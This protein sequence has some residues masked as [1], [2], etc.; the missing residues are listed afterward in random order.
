MVQQ[1]RC[2]SNPWSNEKFVQFY[3]QRKLVM[4]KRDCTLPT[5]AIFCPH[6][7]TN[8]K[9]YPFCGEDTDFCGEDTDFCEKT[10]EI[11]T[12]ETS[13][14]FTRKAVVNETSLR[15]LSHIC[16][17]TIGI[18]ASQLYPFSMCHDMS[19]GLG[20]ATS[21][22]SF[23]KAYK[24]SETKKSLSLTSGLTVRTSSRSKIYLHV[25]PLSVNGDTTMPM[26]KTL[27]IIRT[28]D[29]V[30]L[31]NNK[32]WRYFK[33]G[34]YQHLDGIKTNNYRRLGINIEWL[35][36]KISSSG[37]TTKM[38]F[39]PLKQWKICSILSP[40]KLV[41]L[42]R[43]CTLPTLAIFCPHKWTNEKFYPFCGEDT[44]FCE[45]TREILTVE[46]SIVF[47]RKAVV[48]ETSLRN[49]SHICK[50]TIG[51]DASQLYPFS[52]CHDMSLGL[53]G[54]TSLDSFLKAYKASDTKR[55]FPY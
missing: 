22:D 5:L 14:V 9:F 6:K 53:G 38:L 21:L 15:N 12:G 11:L 24:S 44:D 37:T 39:Q 34:L 50:S 35:H 54:A 8:E 19:L 7:W 30:N 27:R 42:K 43:D 33:L 46:T 52:M 49:L 23:L 31:M 13:I 28:Q 45:K 26:I 3:H 55:F 4:L 48:N 16:K 32:H 2:C 41:M 36:F 10:R 1:Q 47:T 51:I 18:D 17:S 40:E 25:K 20:G 29:Q